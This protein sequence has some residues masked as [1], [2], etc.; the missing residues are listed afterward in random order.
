MHQSAIKGNR[1]VLVSA[2]SDLVTALIRTTTQAIIPV[3][4]E[5]IFS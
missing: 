3:S 2:V 1:Y 5:S 4:A